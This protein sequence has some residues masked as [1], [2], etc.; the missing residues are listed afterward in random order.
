M[1]RVL[2]ALLLALCM[3]GCA[4]HPLDQYFG[5]PDPKVNVTLNAGAARV[6]KLAVMP[7]KASTELIG[8]SV[9]DMFVTELLRLN[10]FTLVER[11]QMEK[12]LNETE[13][14][15]SGLSETKAV[16]VGNMLGADAVLV[17][18]VDE[19]GTVARR[20]HALPVV[21]ISMRIIDCHSGQLLATAGYA[22]KAEDKDTTLPEHARYIVHAVMSGVYAQFKAYPKAAEPAKDA[23]AKRAAGA[24]PPTSAAA[25]TEPPLPPP[26]FT[27]SDMG[28]REVVLSWTSVPGADT[29]LI[30]RA[31]A[32]QGPFAE[33]ARVRGSASAYTDKQGLADATP[34]YYRLLSVRASGLAGTPSAVKESMTAP[35]R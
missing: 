35:A 15:L 32:K 14:Q 1:L 4:T 9:S 19:Y 30:E 21:G 34:Y 13:V 20:K 17:G 23:P 5:E 10:R 25:A 11:S 7:F 8:A 22:G 3:G 12:V 16:A 18:T 29:Y 33:V 26:E 27:V 6:E 24:A 28:A 31:T 2:G